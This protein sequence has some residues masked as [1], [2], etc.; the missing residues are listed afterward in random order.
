MFVGQKDIKESRRVDKGKAVDST[1]RDELLT[2]ST[3][4][5]GEWRLS[6]T[7]QALCKRFKNSSKQSLKIF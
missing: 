6:Y 3:L 5:K 7:E 4:N 2:L 1:L